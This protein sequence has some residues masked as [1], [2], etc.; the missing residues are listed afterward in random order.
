MMTGQARSSVTIMGFDTHMIVETVPVS[1]SPRHQPVIAPSTGHRATMPR[2]WGSRERS[3][4]T[5]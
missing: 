1:R 3:S 4:S 5:S 2:P